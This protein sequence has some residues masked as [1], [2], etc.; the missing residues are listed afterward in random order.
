MKNPDGLC[1]CRFCSGKCILKPKCQAEESA[2]YKFKERNE[3]SFDLVINSC[4]AAE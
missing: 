3:T 2:Y 1:E 4:K